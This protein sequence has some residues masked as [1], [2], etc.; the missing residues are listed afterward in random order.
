MAFWLSSLPNGK[1]GDASDETV[2]DARCSVGVR[3]GRCGRCFRRW[4]GD[5]WNEGRDCE[6]AARK[7]PCRRQRNNAVRLRAGHGGKTSCY[8]ACA[9]L[10]RPLLTKGK[11]VAGRGVRASVLGTTK[12]R[13]GKL[14]VTYN[15]HPLYYF[16]SDTK[17]GQTTGQDINQ[18]G[19]LWWVLARAGNEIHH[20]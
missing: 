6:V 15:G 17:P 18:F 7:H 16:V 13:D 11:P 1:S 20:G 4:R 14:E 19:A 9:A 12:R 5:G 2:S 8:D 3:V 10:W